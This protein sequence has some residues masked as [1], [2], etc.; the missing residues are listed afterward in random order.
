MDVNF[1][2]LNKDQLAEV[3]RQF[4]PSVHQNPKKGD[5]EGQPYAKQSLINIRSGLN[6]YL[7]LPPYNKTWD[8][9]Q[10]KEFLSANRVFK[11]SLICVELNKLQRLCTENIFPKS[12]TMTTKLK[13]IHFHVAGNLRDQKEKGFDKSRHHP[14]LPREHLYQ[15][16]TN[17]FIPHY[18][19]D[20]LCL[21]HKV[22]FDM[23]FFLGKRGQEGLRQ[24]KKNSFALKVNESGSEYLELTYNESTKK[25]QGD[26][27]R[28]MNKQPILLS[29][30]SD[31]CPVKSFKLY[32]SKLTEIEPLLQS[33]NIKFRF[34]QD[35]WYKKTA[36]GENTIGKF[37][38][39][40]SKN[41]GLSVIYTN[42]CIRGTTATAMHR[43]GYSLHEIAQVTRH[44]NIESLK[45]YLEQPTL[46]DMQNYSKSLFDYSCQKEQNPNDSDNENFESPPQPTR[47]LYKVEPKKKNGDNKIVPYTKSTDMAQTSSQSTSNFMQNYRENPIGMFVGANLTNCTIN[48]NMPK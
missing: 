2:D 42:H 31:R 33:P 44:K 37:M 23:A 43:S 46:E 26:D 16:Y 1:E 9:M 45:Y 15:I 35:P 30:K 5:G 19:N 29:Q 32:L 24:L 13:I 8:L 25:S 4:Y 41:A 11:G 36:V 20:P 34:P 17:Y 12:I 39:Q 10:D 18:T 28:E 21:Q 38:K 27:N 7:Q 22:Y 40:I 6:R 14:P 47:N 3:L 48:I